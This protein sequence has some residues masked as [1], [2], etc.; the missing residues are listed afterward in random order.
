MQSWA[1]IRG[2]MVRDSD[3]HDEP[4]LK[5]F[6][7]LPAVGSVMGWPGDVLPVF[8]SSSLGPELRD[9]KSLNAHDM[10]GN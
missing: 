5:V 9:L 4:W 2:T 3:G 10:W 7:V 6:V 8:H 1:F